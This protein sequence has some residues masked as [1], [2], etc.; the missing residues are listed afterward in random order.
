MLHRL[1]PD[2]LRG[3]GQALYTVLGYGLSG[4]V[5]GIGGGWLIDRWGYAA[6]FWAASGA[7]VLAWVCA[8]QSA[9]HA[10]AAATG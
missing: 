10:T 4:V 9:R 7:A 8:R 1:F 6:A 3:R 5:A 2:R